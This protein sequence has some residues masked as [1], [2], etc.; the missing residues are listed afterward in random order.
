MHFQD[1]PTCCSSNGV[2]PRYIP[3]NQSW[4]YWAVSN[5]SFP[6]SMCGSTEGVSGHAAGQDS[7]FF[8]IVCS[9]S[10]RSLP[11]FCC[12]C[13]LCFTT[14]WFKVK[15]NIWQIYFNCPEPQKLKK[16]LQINVV[17]PI[18]YTAKK[19]PNHKTPPPQ[20]KTPHTPNPLRIKINIKTMLYWAF[21]MQVCFLQRSS[22]H[23][24]VL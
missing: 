5:I 2:L 19:T 14:Q 8:V 18:N 3:F 20:K 1:S 13:T 21:H 16:P 10:F 24:S 23:F 15:Q 22:L 9:L 12:L 11:D 4:I 7:L 6:I 17:S